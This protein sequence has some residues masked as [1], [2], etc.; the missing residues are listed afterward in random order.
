MTTKQSI[1]DYIDKVDLTKC[2][3]PSTLERVKQMVKTLPSNTLVRYLPDTIKRGDVLMREVGPCKHPCIVIKKQGD[4]YICLGIS[5]KSKYGLMEITNSRFWK[6]YYTI[7]IAIVPEAEA[8]ESYIGTF[9]NMKE[10]NEALRK[11]KEFYA[12][13]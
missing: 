7:G 6:G 3:V 9:D 8:L 2:S 5:S 13:L 4:N 1:F 12:T 10:F 11:I